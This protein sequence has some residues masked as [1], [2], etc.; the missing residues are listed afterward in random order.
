MIIKL[1]TLRLLSGDRENITE[2]LTTVT[3]PDG[4]TN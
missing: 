1:N 2:S 3:S 4:A